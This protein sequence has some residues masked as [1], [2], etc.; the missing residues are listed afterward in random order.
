MEPS[1]VTNRPA[2][3]VRTTFRELE[4]L[5]LGGRGVE[6]SGVTKRPAVGVRT[7]FRR[8]R[9]LR[10]ELKRLGRLPVASKYARHRIA[11]VQKALS[12][13]VPHPKSEGN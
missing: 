12:L 7:T 3:G 6:P 11:I 10:L 13:C 5:S 8:Q 2:F 1:E 9:L 4:T